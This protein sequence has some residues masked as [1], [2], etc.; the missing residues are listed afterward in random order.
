MDIVKQRKLART[1]MAVGSVAAISGA[2]IMVHGELKFG[3]AVLVTGM[4]LLI[5]GTI[6]LARTPTGENGD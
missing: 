6:L 4:L 3:D 5:V 1:L 2:G